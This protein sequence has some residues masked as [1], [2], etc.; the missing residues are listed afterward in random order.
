MADPART[1]EDESKKC[2]QSGSRTRVLSAPHWLSDHMKAT[3]TDRC[4][5]WEARAMRGNPNSFD[6]V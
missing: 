2:S 1:T 4:T 3:Y 5:N 6:A